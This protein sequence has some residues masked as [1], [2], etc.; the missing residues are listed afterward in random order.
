MEREGPDAGRSKGHVIPLCGQPEMSRFD[1]RPGELL[2]EQAV[3][4]PSAVVP[5]PVP[6]RKNSHNA[7]DKCGIMSD[8]EVV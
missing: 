6:S 3:R 1:N 4:E 7:R 5:F 2:R 8:R